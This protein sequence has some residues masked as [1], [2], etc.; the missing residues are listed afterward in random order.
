MAIRK[1]HNPLK[2][3]QVQAEAAVSG[4]CFGILPK[5]ERAEVIAYRL[6]TGKMQKVGQTVARALSEC[7]FKFAILLTVESIEGNGKERTVTHYE[8]LAAA[9]RHDQ[10]IDHLNDSHNSL[11]DEEKRRG[12]EVIGAGWMTCPV[13]KLPDDEL[14]RLMLKILQAG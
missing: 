7:R 3:Y 8:R 11:L 9:Y 14:E 6:D 13:P 2:R 12:N 5:A 1:K 4:L 10:L